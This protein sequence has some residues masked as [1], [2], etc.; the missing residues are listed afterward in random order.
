MA[1]PTLVIVAIPL[2]Y[3]LYIKN[4]L[5]LDGLKKVN[6][7]LYN[8]LLNK[9]YFDEL[10]NFLLVKPFKSLGFFLWKSGDQ[11]II[12]RYGPDGFSKVIKYFSNKAVKFQSG[13]I[14]DYAFAMLLGLSLLLT[15]L[16]IY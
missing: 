15:Y 6:E 10:Y 8:F 3:Y 4:T 9:W 1:T 14:Y 12:D 11:N 13:F 7:P 2:T 5:I 16:M